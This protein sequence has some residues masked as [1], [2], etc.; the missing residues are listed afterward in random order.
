MD[1]M[2]LR[3]WIFFYLICFTALLWAAFLLVQGMM[4]GFAITIM[5][6]VMGF[7]FI[8]IMNEIKDSVRKRK[9]MAALNHSIRQSDSSG[10][11]AEITSSGK[12]GL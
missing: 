12:Q 10:P 3:T 5:M 6:V 11:A 9:E 7:N 4:L 2:N 8:L 1:I